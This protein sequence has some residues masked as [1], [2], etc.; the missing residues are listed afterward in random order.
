VDF[1]LKISP[2][3]KNDTFELAETLGQFV[4]QVKEKER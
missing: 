2:L 4:I 3:E 1:Q